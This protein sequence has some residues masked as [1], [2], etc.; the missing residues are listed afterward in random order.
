MLIGSTKVSVSSFC[1]GV[2][3]YAPATAQRHVFWIGCNLAANPLGPLLGLCHIRAANAIV[4]RTTAVY[5]SLALWSEAPHVDDVSLDRAWACLAALR[6][7]SLRCPVHF[8]FVSSQTPSTR[9]SC[10][11]SRVTPSRFML[12]VRLAVPRRRV[13]CISSYFC[14]AN[15]SGIYRG[16]WLNIE[17]SEY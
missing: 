12:A 8:S 1:V 14:A 16:W 4:G 11:G 15:V 17:K 5:T 3:L 6:R 7:S 2:A 9:M 10:F 13:K